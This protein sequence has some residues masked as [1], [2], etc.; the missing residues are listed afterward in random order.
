MA[1]LGI[2]VVDVRIKPDQPAGEVS[3]SYLPAYAYRSNEAVA[4]R[5]RSQGLEEAMKIRAVADKTRTEIW[6]SG[7]QSLSC[8]VRVMRKSR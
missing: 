2:E 5:H 1:A 8:V 3:G 4:R 7:R 6:R